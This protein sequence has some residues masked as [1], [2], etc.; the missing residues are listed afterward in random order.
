MANE[1]LVNS[2]KN[3]YDLARSG[4]LEGAYGEYQKLF[5]SE[6]FKGYPA[7]ERRQALRMMVLAKSV[8]K[9]PPPAMV[10]A[11]RV[12]VVS[13]TQLVSERGEPVDYEMLGLCHEMLGNLESAEAAYRAGLAAESERNPQSDLCET[14]KKRLS[15]L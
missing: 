7:D 13:L 12:A 9:I 5:A 8:P 14:F 3:I 11:Y 2:I 15:L 1:E 4:N 10:D 6:A